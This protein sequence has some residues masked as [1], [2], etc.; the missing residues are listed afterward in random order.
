MWLLGGRQADG[1]S[2]VGGGAQTSGYPIYKEYSSVGLFK[3]SLHHEHNF[4]NI[5]R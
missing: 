3:F 5:Y 2:P 1:K 4:E